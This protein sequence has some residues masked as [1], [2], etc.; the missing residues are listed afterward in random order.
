LSARARRRRN[1]SARSRRRCSR[2]SRGYLT[3]L[4]TGPSSHLRR[5]NRRAY[6]AVKR[7]IRPS[8]LASLRRSVEI[9]RED[10]SILVLD[11]D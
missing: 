10:G 7:G 4:R 11:S 3:G 1:F 6:Q 2:G 8:P 5:G 9:R